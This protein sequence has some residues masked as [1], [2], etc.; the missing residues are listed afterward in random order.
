MRA[1]AITPGSGSLREAMRSVGGL[2][3]SLYNAISPEEVEK[4]VVYMKEFMA[5]NKK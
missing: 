1:A 2:R 5:D 4:L 3:I